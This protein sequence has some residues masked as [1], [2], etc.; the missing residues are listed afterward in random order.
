MFE[1]ALN[2]FRLAVNVYRIL[3]ATIGGAGYFVIPKVLRFFWKATP[4]SMDHQGVKC[5]I[6]RP[7]SFILVYFYSLL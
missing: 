4:D 1:S 6:M 5:K 2:S 7:V 3:H